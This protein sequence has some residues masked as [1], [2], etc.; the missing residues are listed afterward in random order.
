VVAGHKGRKRSAAA[1]LLLRPPMCSE[2][3]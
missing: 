1:L 3:G 2:A